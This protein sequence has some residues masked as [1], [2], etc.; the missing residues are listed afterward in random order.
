MSTE[1]NTYEVLEIHNMNADTA[2]V[3]KR[4]AEYLQQFNHM[5]G[6]ETLSIQKL[7]LTVDDKTVSAEG[8]E[9]AEA[10][11]EDDLLQTSQKQGEGVLWPNNSDV[12]NILTAL[13]YAKYISMKFQFSAMQLSSDPDYGCA[14]FRRLLENAAE[15]EN[16]ADYISYKCLEY[17]DCDPEVVSYRF[18]K[19]GAGMLPEEPEYTDDLSVISDIQLWKEGCF[20]CAISS[21]GNATPC[22][23]EDFQELNEA[24]R[25]FHA[26]F[27]NDE[28]NEIG[29]LDETDGKTYFQLNSSTAYIPAEQIATFRDY[30]QYFY[31]FAFS[32]QMEFGFHADFTPDLQFELARLTFMEED[33]KIAAKVTRY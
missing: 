28:V 31:D 5:A 14:Y 11:N 29:E 32:H 6:L 17:Y 18:E 26:L 22:T 27:D 20:G 3:A 23:G 12:I 2:E 24:V 21:Y 19:V 1:I 10:E 25:E 30:L 13:P 8:V 9:E 15:K 7:S 33:G 4:L 16:L